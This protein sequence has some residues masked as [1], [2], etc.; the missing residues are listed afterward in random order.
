MVKSTFLLLSFS[1]S[2]FKLTACFFEGPAPPG[3]LAQNCRRTADEIAVYR[4][5]SLVS[6]GSGSN[7]S[8]LYSSN[9]TSPSTC[10]SA[11]LYTSVRRGIRITFLTCLKSNFCL[12]I[13]SY[14]FDLI[15]PASLPSISASFNK[16]LNSLA[17]AFWD[18]LS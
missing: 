6:L 12:S 5:A 15:F 14:N 2:V 7:C 8:F 3:A 4:K 1:D 18:C 10:S 16:S 17:P 13:V 11:L 9:T